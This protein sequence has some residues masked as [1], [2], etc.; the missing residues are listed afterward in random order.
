M[1]L[2]CPHCR[3]MLDISGDPPRFCPY[4]GKSLM[5]ETTSLAT[6][7]GPAGSADPLLSGIDPEAT[8]AFQALGR[9]GGSSGR[10]GGGGGFDAEIDYIPEI[11]AGFR[12]LRKLGQGGM[13]AVH[14]AEDLQTGR[15]VAIKVM[16]PEYMS[17]PR[18]VERFLQEGRLA[19][20]ISHPRCVFVLAADEADGWPFIVMELMPG[21]TLKDLVESTGPLSTRRAIEMILDVI[22]GLEEAHRRGVIHRDVKPSNCFL[23]GDGR[24]KVGD[25]GLS[26]SVVDDS[27]LTRTGTFIGTPHFA[28]AEQI[29]GEAIDER[30]DVYSVCA[31]LFYLITG[32]PPF[33]GADA[34]STLAKIVSDP[35]PSARVFRPDLWIPLDRVISRGLERDR[36]RRWASLEELRHA[37]SPFL[38]GRV[39]LSSLGLRVAAYTTDFLLGFLLIAMVMAGLG[40]LSAKRRFGLSDFLFEELISG[41]VIL[42]YYALFEILGEASPGKRLFRLRVGSAEAGPASLRCRIVRLSIFLAGVVLPRRITAVVLAALAFR[43]NS[44]VLAVGL[45]QLV[46]PLILFCTARPRNGYRGLHEFASGTAV[47]KLPGRFRRRRPEAE[48]DD[49]TAFHLSR[50]AGLPEMLGSFKVQGALRWSDSVRLLQAEDEALRRLVWITMRPDTEAAAPRARTDLARLTRLRWLQAGARDGLRWDAF[51]APTGT[52]LVA[53]IARRRRSRAWAET[54]DVLEELASELVDASRDGTTPAELAV[55]QVWIKPNGRVLLLDVPPHDPKSSGPAERVEAEGTQERGLE[56]LARVATTML[57]AGRRDREPGIRFDGTP[58]P[59]HAIPILEGLRVPSSY[60]TIEDFRAAIH[61]VR[62]RPT[63]LSPLQQ[64]GH[65]AYTLIAGLLKIWLLPS[66]VILLSIALANLGLLPFPVINGELWHRVVFFELFLWVG[67]AMLFREGPAGLVFNV[68]LVTDR[69]RIPSRLRFAWR[70]SLVVW[71]VL[72][73]SL[74]SAN[75]PP[76]KNPAFDFLRSYGDVVFSCLWPLLNVVPVFFTAGRY[77]NDLLGRTV[78][79]PR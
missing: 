32:R 33:E 25:F 60:R 37:L 31:T 14:E 77:L 41:I 79:V 11:L 40:S 47:V 42:L 39:T 73:L 21:D 4:C 72:V 22:E 46:G 28:S 3:K 53:V 44:V 49:S 78:L 2:N 59:K 43:G 26:K 23:D 16:S 62:D 20:T 27:G 9:R 13:G 51:V 15:R 63:A 48:V 7:T 17:S 64:F 56:L 75:L 36:K 24:I 66:A 30:S 35:L 55:D 29:K 18:A 50:P 5:P 54:R 6:T 71:P 1:S 70:E 61:A 19:S 68:A 58:I 52:P 69:G 38:P 12:V 76:G 10:G 45:A 8:A 67:L 57:H 34:A 65:A 74:V